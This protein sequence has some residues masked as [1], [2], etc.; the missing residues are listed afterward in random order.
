[1]GKIVVILII[2]ALVYLTINQKKSTEKN[3]KKIDNKQ[4]EAC[5][6]EELSREEQLR[7]LTELIKVN[8]QD[9]DAE[10]QNTLG[11]MYATG[12]G[13]YGNGMFTQNIEQAK[14]WLKKSAEQG[15]AEAQNNLG[16][17]CEREGNLKNALKYYSMAA[18]QNQVEG[19]ISL[20]MMYGSG[21][22]TTKDKNK[23]HE[24]FLRAANLG[25]SF[26][27]YIAGCDYANGDG[28]EQNF[29][30]AYKWYWKAAEQGEDHA[31]VE[32]AD[33]YEMQGEIEK[34]KQW[35]SKAAEQ[36]NEKAQEKLS[37]L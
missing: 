22:G 16:H 32:I 37:S 13:P 9:G 24:L 21:E 14:I 20:A 29:E 7:N 34:A 27:Q 17:L 8:A 4:N 19:L 12:Q 26:A 6:N 11:I 35:Y 5:N 30:E 3:V 25:D 31:Q 18:E 2:V 36:G 1:M 15:Y 33:G 28:V 23:A 10:Y